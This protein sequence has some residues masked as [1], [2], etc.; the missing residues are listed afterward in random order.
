MYGF[1]NTTSTE[2]VS[3]EAFYFLFGG[4]VASFLAHLY[5]VAFWG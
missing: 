5:I 2:R 1:M 3:A 4:R